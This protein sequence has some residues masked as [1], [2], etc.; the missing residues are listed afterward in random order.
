MNIEQL[1]DG[2][3]GALERF[4]SKILP[5]GLYASDEL[6][7]ARPVKPRYQEWPGAIFP[8]LQ[9]KG[10]EPGQFRP[11][12]SGVSPFNHQGLKPGKVHPLDE[13]SSS[14]LCDVPDVGTTRFLLVKVSNIKVRKYGSGY[15]VDK[16]EDRSGRWARADLGGAL[17]QMWKPPA[18]WSE[19]TLADAHI[20][21]FIGFDKTPKSFEKELEQLRESSDWDAHDVA[22]RTQVWPDKAERGFNVRVAA[23]S[24][25]VNRD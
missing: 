11:I 17:S 7:D 16:H 21:I 2:L 13:F 8:F 12:G 23:W 1:R 5:L 10:C 9:S 14:L 15:Q 19:L 4:D 22:Y 20:V 24:R 3:V 6:V 18:T 25:Q